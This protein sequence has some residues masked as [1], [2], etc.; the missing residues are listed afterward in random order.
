MNVNLS[1]KVGDIVKS[2]QIH[3]EFLCSTQSGMNYSSKTKTL[4]L[5]SHHEGGLYGDRW[6]EDILHYT[7]MGQ[8]G[9]MEMRGANL[10]LKDAEKD[11]T[12]IH[13]FEV[14]KKT[15]YTYRGVFVLCDKPYQ[16]KQLDR[17]GNLRKVWMFPIKS[18][19]PDIG[20]PLQTFKDN[21]DDKD[22]NVKKKKLSGKE[23]VTKAKEIKN[24]DPSRRYV[25]SLE[26][27][28]DP[29]IAA[30]A[31][32][33]AK[34]VCLLCNNPAPFKDKDGQPYLECHHIVWLSEGGADELKNTAA[35]CPNCHKKMHVVADP[36]DVKKLQT[37]IKEKLKAFDETGKI[38]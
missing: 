10:R 25:R 31:K 8:L 18:K 33:L 30:A 19:Q 1:F 32:Y 22:K 26:Y 15:E 36:E 6:D 38:I 13:L 34:G 11:G 4:V 23:L 17:D 24:K 16:E 21:N 3:D 14:F 9:D 28:R 27:E 5:F 29:I 35:L 7:G 2:S 20:I 37:V 12:E